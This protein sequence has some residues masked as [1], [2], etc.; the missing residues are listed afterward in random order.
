M[1][2]D[3]LRE[4]EATKKP[5]IEVLKELGYQYIHP[6]A[7]PIAKRGE[8][9]PILTEVLEK[10]LKELNSYEY[11]GKFYKFDDNTIEKAIKDLDIPIVDG[12]V[13]TSEKIYDILMLGKAYEVYTEDG[14]K[15]SYNI[16]YIDWENIE[17]NDFHITEEYRLE[18][19]KITIN[20]KHIVPDIVVF[21]NG[22]PMA[23]IEAKRPSI[24][25]DQG[26][27][28]MIRNQ[29]PDYIP[30]LFKFVQIVMSTNK[31][32][33]MYATTGTPKK[34]WSIWREKDEKWQ[35]NILNKVVKD[36]TIT[37]QD[38]YLV[39]LFHRKRFTELIRFF[40]LFDLNIKKIARY[41][42]YFGV[43]SILERVE[44]RDENGNR[45]S[46]VIWHTQ[47]SGKSL[48]MV[49]LARYISYKYRDLNPKIIVVTDR[50]NLDDQIF[51]TFA[52]TS[53]RPKQASTGRHLVQL[54]NDD[55]ADI[56]TT[57]VNK[58]ET[59]ANINKAVLSPDIFI[60]VD[61]SHRTQYGR[62][63]N[64]MKQLF[65][66]ASYLGFTGTPLMKKDKNTMNKFGALI[67]PSYTISDAVKDKMILPLYYEGRMVE[68]TVNQKAIDNNL[69]IITR[70]LNDDQK[71]QV[72]EQWSQFSKIASS[73]QRIKLVAFKVYEDYL[74]R[75]K[76]TPFNALMATYNKID[77]IR[78][79]EHFN[80]LGDIKAEVII[81]PP[82]TREGHDDPSEESKKKELKFW[83]KMMDKYGGPDKYE[84]RIKSEFVNGDIDILIVVDK[85]LTG[86]D[87]PKAQVLYIDK[88]LKEH[89]LLQAIARVNRL[90]EGKDRGLIIDF[91]GLLEELDTAMNM[92][93]GAG[94]ENFDG[95][96]LKGALYDSMAVVSELRQNHSNLVDMFKSVKN[97]EDSEAYEVLLEDKRTRDLFYENLRK[98][99]NSLD[100]SVTLE[101]V[102]NA[103]EGEI[104]EYQKDYKFFYELRKI[105]ALRYGDR[106]DT[107]KLNRHMKELMDRNISAD[108]VSRI[109]H[110][111]NLNH[112]EDFRKEIERLGNPASKADAIYSRI[113]ASISKNC[114]KNPSYYRKFSE[115]IEETLNKYKDKR[116]S[117]KEYL[118]GMYKHYDAFEEKDI[119]SYPEI[120][121][122]NNNAKAFYG[123]VVD[124]IKEENE[125]YK[126]E[127]NEMKAEFAKLSLDIE[128]AISDLT[129]VD[130]H[131]NKD[132]NDSITQA[133]EDLTYDFSQ[134]HGL[135][136]SWAEIDIILGEI[137]KIAYERF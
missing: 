95:E 92:Y 6:D 74:Q 28:Q 78:Y 30:D 105:V 29:K 50:V 97:K 86:F 113:T 123:S 60:L 16:N 129:K 14:N 102:Y 21:I 19:N 43:K 57:I 93:S 69:D 54:I 108:G 89:S 66:N 1:N 117:E 34:F 62:M 23:V 81:S 133:V 51:Q 56:I 90:E 75:L 137:K 59:A 9:G 83:N 120:I 53:L 67:E 119:I 47:G 3:K 131:K 91:R 71:K 24:S 135:E 36:R 5:A 40:V 35:K 73:D 126:V 44:K 38:K 26:I 39:S 103:I 20:E 27:S 85:L 82:D 115:M 134:K 37:E 112:K 32:E 61:E 65:P 42:Q 18:K 109:T 8:K 116:I 64:K 106:I 33:V 31:N 88:P 52:H 4:N 11:K 87:A 104:Q 45:K 12:L 99:K 114:R 17:N 100:L 122:E 80:D 77:A 136:L 46:G 121:K 10:K 48:T 76:G 96:D 118:E 41:Q 124:L 22:I 58:F 7:I 63:H 130:W 84:S 79:F 2:R 132:V 110:Q 25:V 49:M 94:L 68:Q 127:D 70:N 98:L 101:K 111:I 15:R 55:G 125:E 128:E 107:K 13:N 72:M